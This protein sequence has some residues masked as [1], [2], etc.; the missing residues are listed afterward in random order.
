M[1]KH[2]AYGSPSRGELL[3]TVSIVVPFLVNRFY[4]EDIYINL[5]NEKKELQWRL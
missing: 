4:G 3:P 2:N 1:S 5:V